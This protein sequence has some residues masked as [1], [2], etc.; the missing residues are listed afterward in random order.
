MDHLYHRLFLDGLTAGQWDEDLDGTFDTIRP[1][2]SDRLD[3]LGINYYNR[4]TVRSW[5]PLI[6]EVPAFDFFP[7]TSWD[8]HPEGLGEV[9]DI[10]AAYD[11][12]IMVTEN[13]TPYVADR[14]V[15]IL[16]GHLTAMQGAIDRGADVRGY[17][18]WSWVDNYEWNHG[19]DLR[20]GLYALDP[21]TKART[22]R[23]V[24]E[25]LREIARDNAL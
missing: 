25:R 8:P 20:F 19:F 23:P 11:L 24:V 12:P 7:E 18:Y 9:I 3:W 13:G 15:E 22:P 5:V 4:I 2:L 21:E 6:S 1:E 17:L 16:E 10:G 14:G